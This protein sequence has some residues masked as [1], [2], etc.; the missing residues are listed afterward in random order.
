MVGTRKDQTR[1]RCVRER[2]F[3]SRGFDRVR[4]EKCQKQSSFC[5]IRITTLI[6]DVCA[7]FA[8]IAIAHRYCARKFTR[9]ASNARAKQ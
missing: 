1:L 7:S 3:P 4:N 8:L 2:T 9:P 6:K 5:R